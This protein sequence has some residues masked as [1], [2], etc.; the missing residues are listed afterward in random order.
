MTRPPARIL[1]LGISD[2]NMIPTNSG[3]YNKS[4]RLFAFWDHHT[5]LNACMSTYIGVALKI[6]VL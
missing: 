3:I 6:K 1:F 4:A 5:F 2:E